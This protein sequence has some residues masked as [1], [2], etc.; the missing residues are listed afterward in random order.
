MNNKY[1]IIDIADLGIRFM[2]PCNSLEQLISI[3]NAINATYKKRPILR[4]NFV[5]ILRPVL[6]EVHFAFT[7]LLH[8]VS[9]FKLFEFY[10]GVTICLERS[11]F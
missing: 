2:F 9:K 3:N 8:S 1:W 6:Q 10:I 11:G 4:F 7:Y 5:D